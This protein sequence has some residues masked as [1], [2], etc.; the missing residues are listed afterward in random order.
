MDKTN[1]ILQGT[2]PWAS[3]K[4]NKKKTCDK[5]VTS[6]KRNKKEN[7]RK[8]RTKRRKMRMYKNKQKK[9]SKERIYNSSKSRAYGQSTSQIETP[10]IN[11]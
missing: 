11:K 1:L 6:T 7:Q 8:Q 10:N 2:N 4:R 3:R 5:K 9:R